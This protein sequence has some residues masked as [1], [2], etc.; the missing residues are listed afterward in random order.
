MNGMP[1]PALV[2]G[3]WF[4]YEIVVQGDDY[5]VFLSDLQTGVRQ[6]TT[7]FRN[8]DGERGRAPVFIGV[9]AY[10]GNTVVG[11]TSVS[12][13]SLAAQAV[14]D[15][16]RPARTRLPY[17]AKVYLRGTNWIRNR[18]APQIRLSG[19]LAVSRHPP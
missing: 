4:E 11:A 2:P 16:G 15:P 7:S 18:E 10:A 17:N 5:S 6:Q 19:R 1:G 14:V 8:T 13:P 3:V 12:N 9:Q